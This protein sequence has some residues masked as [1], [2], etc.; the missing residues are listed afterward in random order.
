MW[1]TVEQ[2]HLNRIAKMWT[3]VCIL[4]QG[5]VFGLIICTYCFIGLL[6]FDDGSK[7][8]PLF[9]R[10]P[11]DGFLF[12]GTFFFKPT[13]C[14]KAII[15]GPH[16]D[17]ICNNMQGARVFFLN[18]F[19]NFVLLSGMCSNLFGIYAKVQI[20]KGYYFRFTVSVMVCLSIKS[21]MCFFVCRI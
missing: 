6:T 18:T 3:W 10:D 16:F 1:I 21:L 17:C 8:T 12:Y 7:M 5:N 14:E 11:T 2:K 4:I 19:L 15:E 9:Y 20:L 13:I